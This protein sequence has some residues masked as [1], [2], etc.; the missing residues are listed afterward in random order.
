[1][2]ATGLTHVDGAISMARDGQDTARCDFFLCIGN[3]PG[4]DF[5]GRETPR[6]GPGSKRSTRRS[7]F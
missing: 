2:R 5:G 3:Q 6:S 4:L 7:R 1:M